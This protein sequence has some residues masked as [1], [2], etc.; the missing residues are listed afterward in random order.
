MQKKKLATALVAL[1][2]LFASITVTFFGAGRAINT[3]LAQSGVN[4]TDYYLQSG[5]EPWGTTFDSKGN[6]WLA[7]PGCDPAPTCSGSTPP[8]KIAVFKPSSSSWINTWTLPSGYGQALFL[9]F[10]SKGNLWFPLPMANSIGE[11]TPGSGTFQQWP[12]PTANAGPWDI[13]IDQNGNIWFTEHFINQIGEFNPT[14]QTFTEI[15]TPANDSE[16]YGI[17]VDSSNNIW[18][19]EN[20]PSVQLIGEFTAGGKLN[21]YKIRSSP[22]SGVTPH[23]ITVD[24]NGNVWWSEGWVGMIGELKVSQAVPGTNKGVT[25]YGYPAPCSTCNG[26]H[27][28]G[29][30]VDS[31]GLVWFDD[32]LQNIIGSFPDSGSGSFSIYTLPTQNSH[33]HDGLNVDGQNVVWFD[34]EFGNKLGEAVQNNVPPP[35]SPTPGKS[36]TTTPSATPSPTLTPSVTPSPTITPSP[37]PSP[38][39]GVTLGQD[40][41]KRSNQKFWGTASDGQTWGGDA[42][43]NS[44]FSIKNS[45]G[46]LAGGNT[47]YSAVLGPVATNAQVLFSGSISSFNSTNFGAVLRW[48]DGNNWYK[49]YIDGSHLVIQKRVNGNATILKQVA[50]TAKANTSYTL[51]FSISG[52]TLSAKVWQTGTTEPANWMATATDTTFASGY[53]GLR[54]LVEN[55]A[56]LTITSFLAT[57]Q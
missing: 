31:N 20:N 17:T 23:M 45:T 25:E 52:S 55:N 5:Q 33:P 28:S 47:N 12:V 51:R 54:M 38:S 49:A 21:E 35:P 11:L 41:F 36:P 15:A 42:G 40:T 32:A 16:P 1:A 7:I 24:P 50:F 37:T 8:G 22:A 44:V 56:V 19:A 46:Q 39:P 57:A 26:T 43:K 14:T 18:F 10:D 13:A 29:I 30:S 6:V 3:T 2:V 4:I 27:T 9:A 48:T 53:C 34:E